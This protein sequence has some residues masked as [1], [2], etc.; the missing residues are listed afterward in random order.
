MALRLGRRTIRSLPLIVAAALFCALL[1]TR[2]L[3]LA[4][5]RE[6]FEFDASR[7]YPVVRV[8]DGDT[9]LLDRGVRV[10]LLG[11]NTPET[12]H[13]K[14]GVEPLGPAASAFTRQF[15]SGGRVRLEFDRSRRDGFHRV[16]AF[17][18]VGEQCLNEELIR[19][20]YSRAET[21]FPYSER[22]K[23]RFLAAQEEAREAER[24]IWAQ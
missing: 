16:L 20:G 10:R 9:L 6:P 14:K 19:A 7:E 17:V 2:F 21:F 8:V 12:R 22:M 13:P 11:V 23:K 15:V 5:L 24:G 4:P 18:H 3:W 1:A